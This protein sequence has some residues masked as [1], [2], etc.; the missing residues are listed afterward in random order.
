MACGL[1]AKSVFRSF[2]R[3]FANPSRGLADLAEEST[4]ED[5]DVVGSEGASF[6]MVDWEDT[7]PGLTPEA[8]V[9][10]DH[11]AGTSSSVE[12]ETVPAVGGGTVTRPRV[13]HAHSQVQSRASRPLSLGITTSRITHAA[14]EQLPRADLHTSHLSATSLR[15]CARPACTRTRT[16]ATHQKRRRHRCTTPRRIAFKRTRARVKLAHAHALRANAALDGR[17]AACAQA[18][19]PP[20]YHEHEHDKR[21]PRYGRA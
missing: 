3:L 18:H 17:P 10:G 4:D 7:V 12:Y 2:G 19:A 1:P 8:S 13:F 14:L 11:A 9:L 6:D 20:F 21:G 5:D 16:S 15:P